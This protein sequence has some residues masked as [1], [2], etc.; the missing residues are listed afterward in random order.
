[1]DTRT[2]A[3]NAE[4]HAIALIY[5]FAGVLVVVHALLTSLQFKHPSTKR[6]GIV[7]A[8]LSSLLSL[9]ATIASSQDYPTAVARDTWKAE[10]NIGTDVVTIA[11]AVALF[12]TICVRRANRCGIGL[13]LVGICA[14]LVGLVSSVASREQ[15]LEKGFS[16][17]AQWWIGAI[18]LG[19]G[20]VI[21]VIFC[22]L[23]GE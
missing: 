11:A 9:A 6:Y 17:V 20:T 13:N 4:T 19:V 22:C 5:T 1:M 7:I 18:C 10:F 8:V 23:S 12:I 16:G 21:S 3:T 15:Y 14:A 2:D